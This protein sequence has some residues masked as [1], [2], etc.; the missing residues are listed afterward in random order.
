MSVIQPITTEASRAEQI[1]AITR[2]FRR[3]HRAALSSVFLLDLTISGLFAV[4][5]DRPASV[6]VAIA[7]SA[8]VFGAGGMLGSQLLTRALRSDVSLD[9]LDVALQGL[10]ARSALLSWA[11]CCL[12]GLL[13]FQL[14]VFFPESLPAEALPTSLGYAAGIW[15]TTVYALLYGFYAHFF[16]ADL[17]VRWRRDV[18]T[19]APLKRVAQPTTLFRQLAPV[20]VFMTLMPGSMTTLD[21]TLFRPVRALQG[22]SIEGSLL[23]DLVASLWV[24]GISLYFVS[25]ALGRPIAALAAAQAKLEGGDL[26]VRAPVLADNELGHLAESFNDMVKGLAERA[27]LQEAFERFVDPHVMASILQDGGMQSIVREATIMFTDIAGFTAWAEALTP[28]IAFEQ[29][30]DYFSEL[31][32][33]IRFHGGIVN[34]FIGDGV[35]ALFNVPAEQADHAIAAVRAA[36]A[37]RAVMHQ[38]RL[39][40]RFAPQTRIGIHTGPVQAGVIGDQYRRSFAVYG[41]AVNIAA[42]LEQLNKEL[43]TDILMSGQTAAQLGQGWYPDKMGEVI[44]RGRSAPVEVLAI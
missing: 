26:V 5:V 17:V 12:Y 3:R 7:C 11:L 41:D 18:Q 37:I 33:I 38:R 24:I 39:A 15:Y 9:Q 30:N 32:G 6:W 16:C 21:L 40:G 35:V 20:F 36:M 44:L 4:I 22:L 23:L 34:N 2:Q 31:T 14:G 19:I 27:T 29:L 28:E 43:G 8:L 10:P 13:A 25:R 42:R 1:A